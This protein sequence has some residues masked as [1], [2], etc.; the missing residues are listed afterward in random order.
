MEQT[1]RLSRVEYKVVEIVV[2]LQFF[3]DE[4]PGIFAGSLHGKRTN[5]VA[6]T[7]ESVA[8]RHET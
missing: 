2:E 5:D 8:P 6:E 1:K 3:G 7:P 4:R